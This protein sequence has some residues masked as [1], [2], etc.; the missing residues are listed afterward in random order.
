MRRE[1]EDLGKRVKVVDVHGKRRKGRS[2]WRWMDSIK[3][4]LRTDTTREFVFKE[5]L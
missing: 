5:N 2:N 3:H 1:E 4:D